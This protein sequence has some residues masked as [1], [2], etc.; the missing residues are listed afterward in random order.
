MKARFSPDM[1]AVKKFHCNFRLARETLLNESFLRLS[2]QIIA[3]GRIGSHFI[4]NLITTE[5]K[6]ALQ[7]T[8]KQTNHTNQKNLAIARFFVLA[9]MTV[10]SCPSGS[11]STIII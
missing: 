10:Y 3:D 4:R 11:S 5:S 2:K 1:R 8:I 6:A 9:N 7:N